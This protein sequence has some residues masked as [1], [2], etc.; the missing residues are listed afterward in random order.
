M[1]L[2]RQYIMLKLMFCTTPSAPRPYLSGIHYHSPLHF[3]PPL[4]S[5]IIQ[6]KLH[7][8]PTLV[9]NFYI[10]IHACLYQLLSYLLGTY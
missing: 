3:C 9:S 6:L 1:H 4:F 2:A 5:S 10:I 8:G 7:T